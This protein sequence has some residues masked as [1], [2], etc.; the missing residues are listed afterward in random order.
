MQMSR[1]EYSSLRRRNEQFTAYKKYSSKMA[2]PI[3]LT[4]CFA[5]ECEAYEI[6]DGARSPSDYYNCETIGWCEKCDKDF[7]DSH[8]NEFNDLFYCDKCFREVK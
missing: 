4:E 2:Y 1:E 7:C 5:S 8:V 6:G 3:Y